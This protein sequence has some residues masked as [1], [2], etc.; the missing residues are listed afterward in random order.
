V[1]VGEDIGTTAGEYLGAAVGA[2]GLAVDDVRAS[3]DN[4][5]DVV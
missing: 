3:V 2:V 4:I 5:Q 1:D